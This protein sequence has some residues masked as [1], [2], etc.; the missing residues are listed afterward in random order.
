MILN[1][2]ENQTIARICWTGEQPVTPAL[3]WGHVDLNQPE[4]VY[5]GVTGWRFDRVDFVYRIDLER[6]TFTPMPPEGVVCLQTFEG[7]D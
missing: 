7:G 1:L 4:Q 5:Q 2:G 3:A 6:E